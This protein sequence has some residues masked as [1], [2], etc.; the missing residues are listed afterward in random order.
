MIDINELQKND[1]LEF[2]DNTRIHA[3][4]FIEISRLHKGRIFTYS[5]TDVKY[6][7]NI[8]KEYINDYCISWKRDGVEL[9]KQVEEKPLF[10]FCPIEKQSDGEFILG[11]GFCEYEEVFIYLSDL[12]LMSKIGDYTFIGYSTNNEN[13]KPLVCKSPLDYCFRDDL[14][15]VAKYAVFMLTSELHVGGE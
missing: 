10:V 13:P 5:H 1:E 14:P 11:Q 4:T 15:K 6:T 8:S 2:N 12:K 9:L 7:G 3:V